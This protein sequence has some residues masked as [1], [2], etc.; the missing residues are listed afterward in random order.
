MSLSGGVDLGALIVQVGAGVLGAIVLSMGYLIKKRDE[1]IEENTKILQQ[2]RDEVLTNRIKMDTYHKDNEELKETVK[3]LVD[4][5]NDIRF[6]LHGL[7]C[8]KKGDGRCAGG[9]GERV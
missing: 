6:Y 4:C 7:P 2:L 3:G 5:V 9:H 8:S 1:K